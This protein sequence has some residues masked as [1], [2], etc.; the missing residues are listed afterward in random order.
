MQDAILKWRRGQSPAQ[1][2]ASADAAGQSVAPK[3][4]REDVHLLATQPESRH[5]I[6]AFG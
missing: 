4:E 5:Y 6:P 2:G 1:S 3:V